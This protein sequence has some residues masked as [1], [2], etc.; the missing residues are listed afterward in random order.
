MAPVAGVSLPEAFEGGDGM[1][2]LVSVTPSTRVGSSPLLE[3]VAGAGFGGV[4]FAELTSSNSSAD[5][6]MVGRGVSSAALSSSWLVGSLAGLMIALATFAAF[7]AAAS[8][9]KGGAVL[10]D[11]RR[12]WEAEEERECEAERVRGLPPCSRE[13]EGTAIPMA[14]AAPA[15]ASGDGEMGM[16]DLGRDEGERV[17]VLL[18]G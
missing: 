11:A 12:E 14:M 6:T 5:D 4:A 3:A 9:L 17:D 7:M 15:F 16:C 18:P 10:F 8:V 1:S 13:D 2:E